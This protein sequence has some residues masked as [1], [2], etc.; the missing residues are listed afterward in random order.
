MTIEILMDELKKICTQAED[1]KKWLADTASGGSLRIGPHNVP[2]HIE[3]AVMDAARDCA[4][5]ELNNMMGRLANLL[6]QFLDETEEK[7][8]EEL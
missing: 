4:K 7:G 8:D 6:Q 5:Q 3:N 1:T 2:W